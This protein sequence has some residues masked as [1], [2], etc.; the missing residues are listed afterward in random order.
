MELWASCD[1]TTSR[2]FW[3]E[4]IFTL[5][6]SVL[7]THPPHNLCRNNPRPLPDQAR[8]QLCIPHPPPHAKGN[9]SPHLLHPTENK[10]YPSCIGGLYTVPYYL[11]CQMLMCLSH[12]VYMTV[13]FVILIHLYGKHN[14]SWFTRSR[15]FKVQL[16]CLCTWGLQNA[17]DSTNTLLILLVELITHTLYNTYLSHVC[18]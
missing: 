13:F 7:D 3:V 11:K 1:L 6:M 2:A 17:K 4:V 16:Q 15:S 14:I 12:D 5:P 9:L 8:P 10:P 18:L